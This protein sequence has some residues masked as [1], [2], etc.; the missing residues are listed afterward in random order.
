MF[1]FIRRMFPDRRWGG[2]KNRFSDV[3]KASKAY[4][5]AIAS[6]SKNKF[7]I[8]SCQSSGKERS[9][10]EDTL[11]VCSFL[12]AGLDAPV[13]F[14]IYLVADGMGGH[15]SGEIASNLAAQAASKSLID[16][17][18]NNYI[19][20]QQSFNHKVLKHYLEEAVDEA[21]TLIRRRVPGGGTTLTLAMALDD[22]IYWAHI[23]DSRLYL[24][25]KD[26]KF[27]LK[28][29]DHSLVKRLVDLG[30]ITEEEASFHPE[31]NVLYR[32]LGQ[33]DPLHADL[34]Q[35]SIQRGERLM[36]C[37]DGLWGVVDEKKLKMIVAD[38]NDLDQLVCDLVQAAN[39]EGGPDNISVILLERKA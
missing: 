6:P 30:E 34:G 1:E 18:F 22:Q 37:S 38:S 11:F 3:T 13:S 2:A 10:N 32:A 16:H 5:S 24:I 28:T 23:G 29:K 17:I 15:Q 25:D 7:R 27:S 35:F 39:D 20:H 36:I 9:H 26:C 31:R 4:S 8:A 33:M 14:G 19:F 21:Q 12:L